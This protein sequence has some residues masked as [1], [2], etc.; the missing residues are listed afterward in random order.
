M[1]TQAPQ[2]S[3]A[4]QPQQCTHAAANRSNQT[5]AACSERLRISSASPLTARRTHLKS[6]G[7]SPRSTCGSTAQIS[8]HFCP[9][10]TQMARMRTCWVRG[11]LCARSL[12]ALRMPHARADGVQWQRRASGTAIAS[13][14]QASG[15]A[16]LSSK[17]L[18]RCARVLHGVCSSDALCRRPCAAPFVCTQRTRTPSHLANSSH[19]TARR[20]AFRTAPPLCSCRAHVSH[21][22]RYHLRYYTLGEHYNSLVSASSASADALVGES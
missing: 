9:T 17:R 13:L 20:C 12:C 14:P 11:A 2:R 22:C 10:T 5:A 4:L 6:S 15:A 8:R 1:V 19:P 3:P 21:L 18:Q 7:A 16:S